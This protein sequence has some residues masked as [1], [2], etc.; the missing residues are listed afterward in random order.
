MTNDNPNTRSSFIDHCHS[1]WSFDIPATGG[2][3]SFA[4]RYLVVRLG[5]EGM[6]DFGK[7]LDQVMQQAGNLQ[8]TLHV[9]LVVNYRKSAK[10]ADAHERYGLSHGIGFSHGHRIANHD[11]RHWHIQIRAVR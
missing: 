8:D 1:I 7:M 11:L 4:G 5:W 6:Y 3:S 2:L 10:S 9:A